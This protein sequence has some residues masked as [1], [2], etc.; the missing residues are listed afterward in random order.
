MKIF[1]TLNTTFSKSD[2]TLYKGIGIL[3]IILHNFMHNHGGMQIENEFTFKPE[4]IHKFIAITFGGDLLHFFSGVF[5]FLG[6]YGVQIF[7]FFSAYGL[8]IQYEKWKGANFNFVYHR[9]KKIYFL[10]LYGILIC[11]SIYWFTGVS[12]G[13][14]GTVIRFLILASTLNNFTTISLF[15][16]PFWFFAPIIQ[17]YVLFPILYRF[18]TKFEISKI[19]IPIVL[20]LI[21]IYLF[22]YTLDGV[23]LPY[24]GVYKFSLFRN[25]IGHLPELLLGIIMG[26]FKF[27]SFSPLVIIISL[28]V[29][30]GT[31]IFEWMFPLSFLSAT[32]FLISLSDLLVRNLRGFF[33]R[34]ISYL[35][36]ISMILFIVNSPFRLLF[37]NFIKRGELS[38]GNVF[39]FFLFL[40]PLSH[41]LYLIYSFLSK[42]LKI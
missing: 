38:W 14:M 25:I 17:F 19:Y 13:L 4:N 30:V 7:F 32:I 16:G 21:L 15:S 26:H 39:L 29:F 35:G 6:H 1:K 22:Y 40:F 5:S 36:K 28:I 27:K 8:T 37:Y 20:S 10:M 18:V 33:R 9:L 34:I 23:S 2:T 12:Y 42:K 31:Q 11:I 41:V 3:L 24:N